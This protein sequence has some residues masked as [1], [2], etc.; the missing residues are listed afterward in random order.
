VDCTATQGRSIGVLRRYFSVLLA[1][2]TGDGLP[3]LHAAVDFHPDF[4]CDNVGDGVLVD[5]SLAAGTTNTGSDM[6]LAIGD[7]EN[8]G[9]LD[10]FSTNINFGV[11]YVNKGSGTFKDEADARGVGTWPSIGLCIG[12]GTAFADLDHDQYEDLVCVGWGSPGYVWRNK[13]NGTFKLA[14]PAGNLNLLGQTLVPFDFD[15]DGDVDLLV[16]DT[17]KNATP[18][19]YENVSP[20]L[21]ARHWLVVEPEGTLSNRDGVGTIVEV[22]AGGVTMTRPIMA[23]YSFKSGP[24]M[25]AH[26]GLGDYGTADTV[27]IRWP[28]GIV[29]TL[30][31]V[32]GDRYL[33]AV[34]PRY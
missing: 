22:T 9:D 25:N 1:D 4:H 17:G 13:G 34:E 27:I 20:S 19:L 2:F 6:G 24:P 21:A 11:L 23:G 28:S 14:T 32:P 30:A 29:Q 31:D 5:V 12:W 33:E 15:R 16:L 8:D 18:H 3:D 26:F 10:I 7:I